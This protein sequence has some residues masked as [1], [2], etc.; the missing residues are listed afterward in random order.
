MG[1]KRHVYG[2]DSLLQPGQDLPVDGDTAGYPDFDVLHTVTPDGHSLGDRHDSGIHDLEVVVAWK[3]RRE[4][5]TPIFSDR[6][7]RRKGFN[8][9]APEG[10]RRF[11][12][13]AE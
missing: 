4:K 7:R 3:H 13:A 1:F 10:T 5:E 2:C 12:L 6:R 11:R 8:A 9:A